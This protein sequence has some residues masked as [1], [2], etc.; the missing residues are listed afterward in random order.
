MILAIIRRIDLNSDAK[1][2]FS[3]FTEALKPLEGSQRQARLRSAKSR[4][5]R[6]SSRAVTS[7]DNFVGG[8]QDP[9]IGGTIQQPE[10]LQSLENT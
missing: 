10:T 6:K 9:I 2:S 7:V 5:F 4:K 8:Q 3:E 1:L